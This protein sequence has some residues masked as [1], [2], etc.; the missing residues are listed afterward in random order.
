MPGAGAGVDH[1]RDRV[2]PGVLLGG[3]RA[4]AFGVV[5][6]GVLDHA[7]AGVAAADARRLH[8]PRRGEVGRA[9]AHALHARAGGGDLLEV[10]HA[11]RRLEDRVHEDRALEAAPWPRAG[12]AGGRRSGCPTAPSTFGTMITSSLSPISL[13]SL[14]QVVEH[15]RGLERVDAR[16]QLRVAEVDLAAD[17]D[18][19]LAR[20]LLAV[21]RHGVL[22]VAEQDVD[23]GRDVGR[24]GDHLLVG[25]VEEVDH[26]R[27]QERDLAERLGRVD[28]ERLEEVS[29]VPH[30]RLNLP[31]DTIARP[32]TDQS[33]NVAE[34]SMTETNQAE[35]EA[36][37][38]RP[39]AATSRSS[40][41]A[42][43]TSTGRPRP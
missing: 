30:A 22:E 21:D 27:R 15:P 38:A 12:R 8:A 7:V 4:G 43:S 11:V 36:S 23:L 41:S 19:A 33:T 16:P 5:R 29:W 28:G 37:G 26:P 39:T 31:V 20:G 3:R 25:E 18:Q 40:R 13:T 17:L 6:V 42:P 1:A 32:L 9:E 14:R 24:L 2:V 34:D 10:R 35:R